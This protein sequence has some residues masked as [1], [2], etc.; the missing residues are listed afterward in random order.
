[1]R[2]R[3][4]CKTSAGLLA[5]AVAPGIWRC[6]RPESDVRSYEFKPY[7][8]ESVKA[9]V[10]QVTP[11]DG[12]YVHTYFDVTPF[13]PSGRY[14]AV[15]KLP[16]QDHLPEL[17]VTAEVCVIDLENRTIKTIYETKT[18]GFQ[19]GANVQWGGSDKYV[20]TNDFIDGKAVA[21]EIDRE[22]GEIRAFERSMYNVS[23]DGTRAIGFPLELLNV[24]QQGYGMPSRDL[25][26]PPSLTPGAAEDEGVWQTDLKTGESKLL[27]SIAH[28]AE[29][30]PVPPPKAGG[31]YYFWHSKFNRQGTRIM[32]VLRYMR[33]DGVGGRN[34]IV[35]TLDAAGDQVYY[36]P[37]NEDDDPVY[38]DGGGHPNWNPAGNYII[39]KL[40]LNS[41]KK[42]FCKIKYDGSEFIVLTKKYKG[43]GHPSVDDTD[44]YLITDT[45]Q[46]EDPDKKVT[47]QF[48]D[49]EKDEATDVCT[50]PTMP[51][52]ELEG[53]IKALRL[54]GHPA[55]N[56]DHTKVSLQAAHKGNR[57][58][59]VVDLRELM[60]KV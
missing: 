6:S 26:N 51:R 22:S 18:W 32:Q 25:D 36:T 50:I 48:I 47:L 23:R 24:T 12:Y 20:Y 37:K 35:M 21:V 45:Y 13:S 43:T 57:Q 56:R 31:T 8:N 42:R 3:E 16:F 34:P 40:K 28:V 4:F 2:R 54:D 27:Y 38:A 30:V 17:G 59:Y 41:G 60:G 46:G 33:P 1:M 11:G 5:V 52:D 10:T 29:A 53:S 15:T 49:L 9:P 7:R 14:M 39:R 55:W 19:T 58:L 44:R